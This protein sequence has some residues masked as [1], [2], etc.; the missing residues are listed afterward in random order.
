MS[1]N[2]DE[3]KWGI[4]LQLCLGSAFSKIRGNQPHLVEKAGR[5]RTRRWEN[6]RMDRK[7]SKTP[8]KRAGNRGLVGFHE[9]SRS[10]LHRSAGSDE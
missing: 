8:P 10:L 6:P 2:S 5:T 3:K 1:C 7:K 9:S 4:F